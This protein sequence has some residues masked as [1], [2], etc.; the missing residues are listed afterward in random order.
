[1]ENCKP[2]NVPIFVG[3]LLSV[4]QCPTTLAE[5]EYI[6]SIPYASVVASLMYIMVCN[7]PYVAYEVGVLSQFMDNPGREH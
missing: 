5:I 4:E 3:T 7:R 1:M 6:V 2:M